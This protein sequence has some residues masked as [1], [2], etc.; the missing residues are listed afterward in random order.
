MDVVLSWDDCSSQ[1]VY[2][3]SWRHLGFLAWPEG[4]SWQST[5]VAMAAGSLC[6][7]CPCLGGRDASECVERDS[8]G[9]MAYLEGQA[10]GG[11]HHSC[12]C[13]LSLRLCALGREP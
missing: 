7:C 2:G 13:L 5:A 4:F 10:L 8:G 3:H 12:G 6:A 9:E 1:G 11:V